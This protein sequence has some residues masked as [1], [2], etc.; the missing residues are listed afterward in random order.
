VL[1][2][3]PAFVLSQDQTLREEVISPEG[4]VFDFELELKVSVPEGTD[5]YLSLSSVFDER[6]RR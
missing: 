6:S 5:G 4:E 1:S 3:P 2:A